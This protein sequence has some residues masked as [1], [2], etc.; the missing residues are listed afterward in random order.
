MDAIQILLEDIKEIKKMQKQTLALALDT[1]KRSVKNQETLQRNVDD[2]AKHIKR[3]DVLQAHVEEVSDIFKWVRMT[4]KLIKWGAPVG[5][6]VWGFFEAYFK[7]L[8]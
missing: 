4:G 8:S 5:G 3:T 7:W 6:I 2:M 1:Y